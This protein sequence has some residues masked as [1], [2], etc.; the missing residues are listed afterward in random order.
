M[1]PP[2]EADP[3]RFFFFFSSSFFYHRVQKRGQ[4]RA[5][6]CGPRTHNY[7]CSFTAL[8]WFACGVTSSYDTR[9]VETTARNPYK[10]ASFEK[11]L[12]VSIP[13]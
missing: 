1:A 5:G 4:T 12:D 3:E 2:I 10:N 13:L 11:V 9:E 8:K 7:D 6:G